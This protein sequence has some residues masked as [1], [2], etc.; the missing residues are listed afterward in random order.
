MNNIT[1]EFD[2]ITLNYK[3]KDNKEQKNI[4]F[5]EVFDFFRDHINAS[6]ESRICEAVKKL[7]NFYSV[8]YKIV[9]TGVRD[10]FGEFKRYIIII[11]VE[12]YIN[13]QNRLMEFIIN[14]R[15]NIVCN[16]KIYFS[17]KYS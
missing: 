10:I 16:S 8:D 4:N 9:G 11:N 12:C 15:N 2:G 14:N 7:F 6:N 13:N 3:T 5:A 1:F 17:K